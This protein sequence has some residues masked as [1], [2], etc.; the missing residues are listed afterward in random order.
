MT[1]DVYT[2]TGT[3]K[4]TM[5][6]PKGLFGVRVNK[7]LNHL[8]LVRQQGNR[9]RAIAH[10][11]GRGEVIGST[12][13]IF[14]QKGTGN[15]RR[16]PIRS[17]V[18]RGGGKAFGPK[19][20]RNFER[21]M[22]KNMRRAALFSSLSLKAKENVIIGL[23]S[24]PDTVKTKTFMTLLKKLPVPI[25]RRIVIVMP[26]KHKGLEFSARNVPGVKTLLANY[27]NPEDVLG[28]YAMI[29][30]TDAF[31]VAEETF[32]KKEGK[33]VAAEGE[34]VEKKSTKKTTSSKS[35]KK[36]KTSSKSSSSS[37]PS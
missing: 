3:K 23:E 5:E 7:G 2:A 16:G 18:M 4:G 8:A 6:L 11:K 35:T 25:G 22:P 20:W 21:A 28:A 9:R 37:I 34:S 27:L 13:K 30:L 12:K 33:V 17:P 29:F 15:A 1:I 26:A 19:K 31:K 14:Q 10:A 24:Y 32:G 36:N